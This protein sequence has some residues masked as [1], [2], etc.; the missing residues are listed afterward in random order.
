MS[1]RTNSRVQVFDA[2]ARFLAKWTG[3]GQP[4]NLINS[5]K[6]DLLYMCDGFNNCLAKLSLDG[7]IPGTLS[8]FGKTPGKLDFTHNIAI[9]EIKNWRAQK[10]AA[11]YLF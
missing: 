6:E 1:D 2:S 9:A 5:T 3:A 10:F 11:K 7:K 8:C 4:W